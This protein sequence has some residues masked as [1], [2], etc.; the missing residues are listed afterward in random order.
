MRRDRYDNPLST[1]SDAARDHYIR[2]VDLLLGGHAGISAAFQSAVDADPE[3]ALAHVGLA[4]GLQFEGKMADAKAAM[5]A[6]AATKGP[7]TDRED[8]HLAVFDLLISG[9][10]AEAY[11]AI[12][13]HVTEHP[14][15]A[16]VAQT[17]SSVFGLIGFS[18][19]PGREPEILAY[20]TSLLPHYGEDWWCLSQHAFALCENGNQDAA[21]TYIDRSLALN[22]RNANGAHVRSHIYYESGAPELGIAYLTDWLKPY[23][24][25]GYL[26]GHLSWHAALWSLEQGDVDTMWQR[27]ETD[28]LPDVSQGLPINVLTDTASILYRAELAGVSVPREIW[29]AISRYASRFFP[30]TGIGFVDIHAALAH[31]MADDADALMRIVSEPNPVTGDLVTPVAE[32]YR[33]FAAQDWALGT[34]LLVSAMGDHA[35]L[36]GSRAQRDL[37]EFSLLGA[38]LKQGKEDEARRLLALRRPGLVGTHAVHGLAAH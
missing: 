19:K 27:I 11:A 38:L 9:R 33:A 3:F 22:A 23:D 10:T 2:A 13:T 5:S 26:H 31:A 24:R 6:A 25:A 30:T 37:L 36:G 20:T 17:C 15:D 29:I 16:L 32:A 1:Q 12:R 4:R 18:G 28:I 35:R 34:E 14:R 8:S 21:T 7:R